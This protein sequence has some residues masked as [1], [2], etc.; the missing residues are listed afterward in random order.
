MSAMRCVA[1][2]NATK[3]GC[4]ARALPPDRRSIT[5]AMR[6]VPMPAW[7]A[8]APPPPLGAR[9]GAAGRLRRRG[10]TEVL[11]P[12][13]RVFHGQKFDSW[14]RETG[15]EDLLGEWD[16]LDRW[17]GEVARGSCGS[18][19]WKCGNEECGHSWHTS[20]RHRTKPSGTG[21][22]SC[23]GRVVTATNN[24]RVWCEKNGREDLLT[25]WAHP[26]EAPEEFLRAS[27]VRVPW[28][29]RTC[30]NGWITRVGNRTNSVNPTGCPVCNAC[31][32]GVGGGGK[33][34]TA[35]NNLQVWCGANGREDLLEEWAHPDMAPQE[36]LR[37]SSVKVQWDC[38]TCGWQ[39]EARI[40]SRRL[41]SSTSQLNLSRLW[42]LMPQLQSTSQLNLRLAFVD[43]TPQI[44]HETHS[45]QAERW[46]RLV[47][48]SAY[49]E[50]KSGRV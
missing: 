31:N 14:C 32:V 21:C 39:W 47:T 35:T 16:D 7:G 5:C 48:K 9:G 10:D 46:T 49:V 37:A 22:P 6:C 23:A 12:P 41:L 27:N 30:L 25:E 24:L 2:V 38:G 4:T 3:P 20:P 19:R 33:L 43:Q 44:T 45:H 28:K 18:V 42:S 36:F 34:P 17:P 50:L 26:D 11:C 8:R 1:A 13:S 40:N 15:R 29:C